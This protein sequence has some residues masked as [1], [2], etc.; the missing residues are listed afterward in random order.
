MVMGLETWRCVIISIVAGSAVVNFKVLPPPVSAITTAAPS[1]GTT[2]APIVPVIDAQTAVQ[3]L[4]IALA[5][6]QSNA[7]LSNTDYLKSATPNS[8][9]VVQVTGP[10][11]D[12][13]SSSSDG[14]STGAII[15]IAVG[16]AVLALLLLLIGRWT[17][18]AASGTTAVQSVQ[19]R[20]FGD[21]EM[22]SV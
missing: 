13:G 7:I 10:S 16:A 6:P 3:T 1:G 19:Q 11:S 8:V 18:N 4:Q 5:A 20:T 21:Q 15:G 14:L 9:T 12:S 17:K 2:A 22:T